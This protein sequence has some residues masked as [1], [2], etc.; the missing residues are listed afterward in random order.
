MVR[1]TEGGFQF[2]V[3]PVH[4]GLYLGVKCAYLFSITHWLFWSDLRV[5]IFYVLIFFSP[6]YAVR[7]TSNSETAENMQELAVIAGLLPV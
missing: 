4:Q 3:L 6:T 5:T 7:E 1:R 2:T